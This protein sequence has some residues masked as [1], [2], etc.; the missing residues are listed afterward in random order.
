MNELTTHN[1]KNT[2]LQMFDEPI[3]M[4]GVVAIESTVIK[5]KDYYVQNEKMR[6][7]IRKATK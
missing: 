4:L 2:T 1:Y 3:W 6:R 7:S 5:I